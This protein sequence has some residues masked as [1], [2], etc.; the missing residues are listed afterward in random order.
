MLCRGSSIHPDLTCTVHARP[1]C[2]KHNGVLCKLGTSASSSDNGMTPF[3]VATHSLGTAAT[4]EIDHYPSSTATARRGIYHPRVGGMG[5]CGCWHLPLAVDG[6]QG[7]KRVRFQR[8]L[9]WC[10]TT[11]LGLQAGDQAATL[12]AS[13]NTSHIAH[14]IK[15]SFTSEFA[16]HVTY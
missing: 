14:L 8:D 3:G 12:R 11:N 5:L 9:V 16:C 7:W 6:W 4:G 2:A 10:D 1:Y 13:W 15:L